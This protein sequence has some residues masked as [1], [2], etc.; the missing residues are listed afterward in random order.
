MNMD[1]Y[2]VRKLERKAEY[3]RT[4]GK[5]ITCTACNGSKHYDHEG[6]PPC[7]ACGGAGKVLARPT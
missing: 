2:Q 4:S 5:R 3:A 7:E 6:S 1:D